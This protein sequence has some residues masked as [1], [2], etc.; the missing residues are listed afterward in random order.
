MQRVC[1]IALSG[2]ALLA[3]APVLVPIMI[4][5]RF[6]GEREVF[7]IQQR[8][9]LN[10]EHFGLFKFATM[11][12]E[13]PNIGAGEITVKNDPRIL[14]FGQF[15]RK[16]KLN[17]L[18]QLLNILKG[19]ISIVGPRPM[20]PSTFEHYDP[21]ARREL[22][23]VRPGLTGAGSIV[24]RDEE[25]HLDDRDDPARFY[26]EVIIPYKTALEQ[27]Y[28]RN[29]SLRL[30]WLLIIITAWVVLRP[31]SPIFWRAFPDAPRPPAEL[32]IA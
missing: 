9:G 1:D 22:C 17:E 29:Q 23:T 15:L 6:T 20:V 26:R 31:D 21:E 3:L 27:W 18:P 5:L 32:A 30:Y 19:D 24:F 8:V 13:S 16:T 14:P 4:I 7:Y 25:R 2:M 10:G 11:L 12:K 28:V